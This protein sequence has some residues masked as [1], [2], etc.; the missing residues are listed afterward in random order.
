MEDE[1]DVFY[2]EINHEDSVASGMITAFESFI[3]Q[4]KK[5][6]W[7]MCAL[8]TCT[9]W[10]KFSHSKHNCLSIVG[11]NIQSIF[12]AQEFWLQWLLAWSYSKCFAQPLCSQKP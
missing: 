4:R 8:L 9:P 3:S 11:A 1:D 2:S 6:F 7:V 5:L 10:V 12:H